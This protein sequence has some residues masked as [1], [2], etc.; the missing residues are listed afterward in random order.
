MRYKL[1]ISW[2]AKL[3]NALGLR[4]RSAVNPDR[5]AQLS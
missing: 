2:T 5:F 4:R 3:L 1:E